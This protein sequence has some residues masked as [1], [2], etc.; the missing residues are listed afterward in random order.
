MTDDIERLRQLLTN[1]TV[2]ANRYSDALKR[3]VQLCDENRRG[4]VS[5]IEAAAFL[6]LQQP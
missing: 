1:E 3:I 2:A 4:I 5:E 6:A